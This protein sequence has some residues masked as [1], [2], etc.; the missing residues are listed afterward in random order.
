M[1]KFLPSTTISKDQIQ[2]QLF[3]LAAVALVLMAVLLSISPAVRLRAW[4]VPYLWQHWLAVLVWG[5]GFYFTHR[6]TCKLLPGRDPY[7]LPLAALL[8]GWGLLTIWRLEPAFGF[9]QTIWLAFSLLLFN[10]GLRL[11]QFLG[12]LRRYKYVWLFTGLGLTALTLLFGT[13]PNGE[14]PGLWFGLGGIFFQ[15]SEPLKLLLVIFLA[16]YLADRQ[17]VSF[18]L[19][20]LL[21]PSLILIGAALIIL[22]A[23]RDLGTASI[24]ILLY[25]AIVYLASGRRRI[26]I[27]GTGLILAAGAAGYSL[28]NVIQVRINAWLNPWLDPSGS[29]YQIVQS[30][31]AIASGR[32]LGSGLGLGSPRVVPVAISDFIFAAIAE[33]TGL[34]G[35]VALTTLL[36]VLSIRAIQIAIQAVNNY[37]RYLA[38]GL[39]IY[40]MLQS[41]LIIGGNLRLLPLTG[42]TLPFV[43]YGGSSLTTSFIAL[44]MLT[45]LSNTPDDIEPAPLLNERPYLFLSGWMLVCLASVA[46]LGGWWSVVRVDR[47][48]SRTDNPRLSIGDRYVPRGALLDRRNTPIATTV[49][50][51]G[52]YERQLL[53]PPLSL[54]V[55]YIHPVYG[56]AGLEQGLNAYLRGYK[57]T[58]ESTIWLNQ[59]LYNQPPPGL[60]VRLSIDLA[61]QKKA[62]QMLAGQTGALVLLNAQSGEILAMASHPYFDPTQVN[63]SWESSLSDPAAPLVNRATQGEYPPGTALGPFLLTAAAEKNLKIANPAQFSTTLNGKNWGC[64]VLVPK[65]ASLPQAVAAG[66]P[67]AVL[68]L[69]NALE[70]AEVKQ[71]YQR[72][73]FDQTPQ[74]SLPAAE[75]T[76]LEALQS[77]KLAALGQDG[78]SVTPLQ[79]AL[80]AASLSAKG[81]RPSPS[82]AAAVNTP[83]Q[84]WV[85]LPSGKTTPVFRT[86]AVTESAGKLPL[87]GLPAWET[88]ASAQLEGTTITWYLAGTTPSWRGVPLALALVLEEDN[89]QLA[90]RIGSAVLDTILHPLPTTP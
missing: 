73:G 67:G 62:D 8:S 5:G 87:T 43:S 81:I 42:V 7:L 46:L 68:A 89:P 32:I 50:E 86:A 22:L 79:M 38:A 64:T 47:L 69:G 74:L 71:L 82:F 84:G 4:R 85:I 55:G 40:L 63:A 53:Y 65:T 90:A 41:I 83:Q 60:D 31:M 6:Q 75:A 77:Q 16:A 1:E 27:F 23:Q 15:P 39:G 52:S 59:M 11:P 14:G 19:L 88:T 66:C 26:L 57:A 12:Y 28:F 35:L 2:S 25:F 58:P 3:K 34:L 56:Q 29:S 54:T 37:Q 76:P 13:Y 51:P 80:A 45:L 21:A 48:L 36:T 49:G 10:L 30:L 20:Q 33:E 44:L 78:I 9:K 72:L 61:L 70:W 18:N 24:F 17:P